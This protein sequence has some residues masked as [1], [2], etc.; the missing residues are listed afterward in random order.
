MF[1]EQ[2]HRCV[3]IVVEEDPN[4][5]EAKSKA[6]ERNLDMRKNLDKIL[7]QREKKLIKPKN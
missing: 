6:K 2:T 3:N 4:S 5:G 1:D 7:E